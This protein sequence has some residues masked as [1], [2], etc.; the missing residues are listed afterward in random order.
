MFCFR[1]WK[2]NP[3]FQANFTP[4]PLIGFRKPIHILIKNKTHNRLI[5]TLK[6][7]LQDH[8]LFI[9]T[10]LTRAHFLLNVI[11]RWLECLL[12]FTSSIPKIDYFVL[13]PNQTKPHK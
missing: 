6:L 10:F 8:N 11:Q 7:I 4:I 1:I 12:C 2:S 3:P 5:N 9:N 13:E